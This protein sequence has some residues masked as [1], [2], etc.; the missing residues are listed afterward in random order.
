MS[1]L[2]WVDNIILMVFVI[3]ILAGLMRGLVREMIALLT[4]AAAFVVAVLFSSKV[5]ASFSGGQAVQGMV[6]QATGSMGVNAAK[7]LSM[8]SIGASFVGLFVA[9]VIVGSIINYFVS[10]AVEGQGISFSNRLLGGV[11]GL[12]RGFLLVL[13]TVFLI[14][15]TPLSDQPYWTSSQFVHSFQ[16]TIKWMS[17]LVSPG[18][19]NLKSKVSDTIKKVDPSQFLQGSPG[20]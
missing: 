15:L 16:P 1:N 7:P 3:S 12:A 20:Q 4:W 14:Q 2:N 18:L 8:L 9:T 6:N 11:F 19:E 17:D 5:A 10:R 13:F